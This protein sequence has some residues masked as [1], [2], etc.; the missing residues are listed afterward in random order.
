MKKMMII[1]VV[2]SS[3]LM[4]AQLFAQRN[5]KENNRKPVAARVE[6]KRG[7]D[8]KDIKVESVKHNPAT[9]PAANKPAPRPVVIHQPAPRPV[10][11]QHNHCDGDAAA[12]AAVAVGVVGLLALLAN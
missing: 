12:V 11:V 9:R 3:M 6:N 4:P 7:G 1:A 5:Q 10:V 2:V 8:R